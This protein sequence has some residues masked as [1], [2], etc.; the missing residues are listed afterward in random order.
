MLVMIWQMSRT[1]AF[2]QDP[3]HDYYIKR[4]RERTQTTCTQPTRQA[5]LQ[6][7]HRSRLTTG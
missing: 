7:H 4:D 1:G 2:Y 3:G 5:R 6:G